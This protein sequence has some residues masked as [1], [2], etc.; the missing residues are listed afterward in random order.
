MKFQIPYAS[1][2]ESVTNILPM[3][4]ICTIS[5]QFFLLGTSIIVFLSLLNIYS[6]NSCNNYVL[7]LHFQR[8]L[9]QLQQQRL[10]RR[11]LLLHNN[12]ILYKQRMR[13]PMRRYHRH[14]HGDIVDSLHHMI[15]RHYVVVFKYIV[16]FVRR[17]TPYNV[18]VGVNWAV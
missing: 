17:V 14:S 18:Y 7:D 2:I 13:H 15:V 9:V 10:L 4:S 1:L 11:Y 3:E 12:N 8:L 5:L 16:K 6:C